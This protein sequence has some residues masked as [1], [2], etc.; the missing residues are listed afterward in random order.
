MK[1]HAT[2]IWN[3]ERS[4]EDRL[5]VAT[6]DLA[7]VH[8]R[9]AIWMREWLI[10]EMRRVKQTRSGPSMPLIWLGGSVRKSKLQR[11]IAEWK[12]ATI[13]QAVCR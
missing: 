3:R 7:V 8:S 6:I 13:S 12:C 5:T 4:H 9:N 2:G 1:V 10:G 11:N